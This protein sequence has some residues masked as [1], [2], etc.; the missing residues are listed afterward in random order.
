MDVTCSSEKIGTYLQTKD[1]Q[2]PEGS[3]N[4][5]SVYNS[6]IVVNKP[7]VSRKIQF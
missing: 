6:A 7:V 3:N 5:V 2:I 1:R 4:N